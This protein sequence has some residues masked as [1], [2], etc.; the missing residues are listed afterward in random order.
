VICAISAI[1]FCAA[2]LDKVPTSEAINKCITQTP[3]FDLDHPIVLVLLTWTLA[4]Y[5]Q[6]RTHDDIIT[7]MSSCILGT[8]NANL[9]S[10]PGL[11]T[12]AFLACSTASDKRWGEKAW[13]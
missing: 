9:A 6:A 7:M 4:I 13:V 1:T 11:L 5:A 3:H 10:Y 8:S 2:T 12:P